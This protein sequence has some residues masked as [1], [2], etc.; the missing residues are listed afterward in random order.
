MT[1]CK[2]IQ[3]R[4]KFCVHK[5]YI[6]MYAGSHIV[7]HVSEQDYMELRN[8]FTNT[9]TYIVAI[10]K[11]IIFNTVRQYNAHLSEVAN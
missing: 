6:L 1:T 7:R 8:I 10:Y 4:N 2:I 3:V 9:H 5:L 11:S